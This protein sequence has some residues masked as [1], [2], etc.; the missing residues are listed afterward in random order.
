MKKPL[1]KTLKRFYGVGDFGFCMMTAAE[2]SLFMLFLTDVA[3][4]PLGIVAAITT[5]TGAVDAIISLFS[6]A[7]VNMV[8]PMKWGK[9]RSWLLICPPIVLMTFIFQFSKIGSDITAAVI[10]CLGFIISHAAWNLATVANVSLVPMLSSNEDD[11]IILTS[12]RGM[13]NNLAKVFFSYIGPPLAIYLGFALHNEVTGYTILAGL[14]ALLFCI[15]YFAHFKMTEGYEPTQE[16]I[17]KESNGEKVKAKDLIRNFLT[18]YPLMVI[19]LADTGRTLVNMLMSA[20]AGYYYKYIAEDM[21]LFPLHLFITACAAVLGAYFTKFIGKKLQAKMS[22]V[23]LFAGI[24][25]FLVLGRVFYQNVPVFMFCLS[26]VQF[27]VGGLQALTVVLYSDTIVYG[28]WKTGKNTASFIMGM[29]V[30]PSK[31]SQIL[32]GLIIASALAAAGFVAGAAPTPELQVG[33]ANAYIIFP[34]TGAL[35]ASL[36]ILFGFRLNSKKVA[37]MQQ[38]IDER[39]CTSAVKTEQIK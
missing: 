32:K 8:K 36:L 14:C 23:I 25:V 7:I 4:F 20:L 21:G 17:R 27:C 1:S 35:I 26:M 29:I 2:L 9:I 18:N 12:R 13:F 15:G 6:G 30:V 24:T 33:I 5:I 28:E 38:E 31:I 39:K 10:V 19:I 3:K 37:E 16:E 22:C 34:A 11:K